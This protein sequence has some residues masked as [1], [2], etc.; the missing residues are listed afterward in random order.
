MLATDS[1]TL[2]RM[3]T[4][5]TGNA[6]RFENSVCHIILTDGDCTQ[7][8]QSNKSKSTS[9]LATTRELRRCKIKTNPV[10]NGPLDMRCARP[11]HHCG[12]TGRTSV[13]ARVSNVGLGEERRLHPSS[14]CEPMQANVKLQMSRRKTLTPHFARRFR[15]FNHTTISTSSYSNVTR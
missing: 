1:R 8:T 6:T 11:A 13:S 15:P 12:A 4:L 10:S 14:Q 3:T 2:C 7:S 9:T 5:A